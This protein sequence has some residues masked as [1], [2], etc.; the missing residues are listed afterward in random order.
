MTDR[1]TLPRL[2]S[3]LKVLM[4]AH[5]GLDFLHF[6]VV[7]LL[8]QLARIY[9]GVSQELR[10]IHGEIAK[11]TNNHVYSITDGQYLPYSFTTSGSQ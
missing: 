3:F 4:Q 10:M 9:A 6:L 5:D 2:P 11:L 1:S 8:I 7:A